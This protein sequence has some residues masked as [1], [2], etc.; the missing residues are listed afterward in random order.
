MAVRAYD[1]L[2]AAGV[3]LVAALLPVA[4]ARAG[5]VVAARRGHPAG[6]DGVGGTA[7]GVRRRRDAG[8]GPRAVDRLW[9]LRRWRRGRPRRDGL[10]RGVVAGH[11]LRGAWPHGW[12]VRPRT[13]LALDSR[14]STRGSSLAPEEGSD[15]GG[16]ARNEKKRRQ[17][18]SAQRLAAAGIEVPPT[19]APN[20]TTIIVAAVL[21]VALVAGLAVWFLRG[22]G[23]RGDPD[24]H[25]VPVGRRG[26][27]RLRPGGGGRVRGLPLPDLR[28]LRGALRRRPDHGAE[29]QPDHRALPRDRDPRR[30]DDARRATRPGPPTP[31]SARSPPASSRRTT[32]SCSTPSPPSAAPA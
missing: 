7:A 16:A 1:V 8:L 10:R 5:R 32:S 4:G 19:K 30:S 12:S 2:P 28:A 11:R 9:L 14:L 22:S 15:M 31:H 27:R 29:Q 17:D 25:R 18:A 23:H 24:L 6:R 13:F 20:R 26:H 21:A 3:E